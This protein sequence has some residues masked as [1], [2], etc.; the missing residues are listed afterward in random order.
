MKKQYTTV[1]IEGMDSQ[2]TILHLSADTETVL[3]ALQHSNDNRPLIQSGKLQYQKI[4]FVR[5]ESGYK[6]V[7]TDDIIY[8]EAQRN[9]CNIHLTKGNTYTVSIP[10]NEVYDDLSPYQFKKVHRSYIINM[11]HIDIYY[12]NMVV[13]TESHHIPIGREYREI[14]AKEFTQI[15]SR[16]RVKAKSRKMLSGG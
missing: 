3:N 14:I 11:S 9:Y 12:G 5:R 6:K 1:I 8:L 13:M 4:I 7:S 2:V 16:K 10:M 15:G